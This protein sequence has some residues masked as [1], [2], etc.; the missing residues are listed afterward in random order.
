MNRSS[1]QRGHRTT[2][3]L[4][5]IL[6]TNSASQ[7]FSIVYVNICT[8]DR[9]DIKY[10]PAPETKLLALQAAVLFSGAAVFDVSQ[11]ASHLLLFQR[12]S[13]SRRGHLI[14]YFLLFTVAVQ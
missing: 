10:T 1:E 12:M 2:E 6:P 11:H 5:S 8:K 9:V 7:T 4:L 13:V 3:V 14:F